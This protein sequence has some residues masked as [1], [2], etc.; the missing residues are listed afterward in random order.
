MSDRV[1]T[2]WHLWVVGVVTFIWN[3]GGC[4]DFVM[5]Q[6]K[7]EGYMSAFTPEQLDY[8]YSFPGWYIVFWALG[9]WFSLFG[10]ALILFRT[11]L[12]LPVYLVS[13]LGFIVGI[14]YTYFVDVLP[15]VTAFNYVFTAAIFF[16]LL[17]EVWYSFA[18]KKKGVLL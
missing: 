14:G 16:I 7:N 1:K 12:A 18:M 15:G 5:T 2:P 4:V 3:T 10:S 6:T 17:F 13:L 9:V 11:K 8:F